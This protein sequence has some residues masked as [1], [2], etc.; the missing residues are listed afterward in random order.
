MKTFICYRGNSVDNG[1]GRKIG[2]QLVKL[3]PKELFGEVYYSPEMPDGNFFT[4]ARE[5]ISKADNFFVILTPNFF[6]DFLIDGKINAESVTYH[7]IKTALENPK[8]TFRQIRVYGFDWKNEGYKSLFQSIYPGYEVER[9]WNRIGIELYGNEITQKDVAPF[10]KAVKKQQSERHIDT[11]SI[12]EDYLYCCYSIFDKSICLDKDSILTDA[13]WFVRRN[14]KGDPYIP[15]AFLEEYNSVSKACGLPD[16]D[17]YYWPV[18]LSHENRKEIS[19]CAI[20]FGTLIMYHWLHK[21]ELPRREGLS[22][23]EIQ[24]MKDTVEGALNLLI[25][26][27]DPLEGYWPATWRFTGNSVNG[28][29]NQTTLSLSTLLSCDFLSETL[30]ENVFWARY[31]YI[32]KSID[33]LLKA[34]ITV[35]KFR[36]TTCWG[37]MF[38]NKEGAVLPTAYAV[39]TLLKFKRE[40]E[41]WLTRLEKED[42]LYQHIS[43][44]CEEIVTIIRQ[45]ANYFYLVY[46]PGPG[47]PQ[48]HGSTTRKALVY[49][50]LKSV[51]PVLRKET[52]DTLLSGIKT[53]AQNIYEELSACTIEEI[54]S[55][56]EHEIYENFSYTDGK[57]SSGHSGD[58]FHPSAG[59]NFELCREMI[60]LNALIHGLSQQENKGDITELVLEAFERYQDRNVESVGLERMV[61]GHNL[62]ALPYP[63]FAMYYYH[64]V[65]EN[66]YKLAN[67]IEPEV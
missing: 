56:D 64:M 10:I 40:I 66:L 50:T 29:I 47:R 3:L 63:I 12:L 57:V 30:D 43:E 35:G 61:K 48:E 1:I 60:F 11:K 6:R 54:F 46:T 27:R 2:E 44:R 41:S 23:R 15:G 9:L 53:I 34:A 25:M 51:I 14:P 19:I 22:A 8:C 16:T 33:W 13:Y 65:L 20:C 32:N 67:E 45:A 31:S 58:F 49:K 55:E 18:D 36:K 28:T 5:F 26:L 39:D 4:T 42:A 21:E 37:H 7:E 17:F 62:K 59:E 38:G 24:D 52:E